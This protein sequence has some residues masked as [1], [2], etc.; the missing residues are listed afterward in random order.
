[1][2]PT[3]SLTTARELMLS[4]QLRAWGVK[5]PRALEAISKMPKE[6][7]VEEERKS[8]AYSDTELPIGQGEFSL[9]P[10]VVGRILES[11]A[12]QERDDILEIG[13]G[14]GYLTALCAELGF[15]VTSI[16]LC[17]EF[18]EKARTNLSSLRLSN[19]H[20]F[21]NDIFEYVKEKNKIFDVVIFTGSMP[22]MLPEFIELLGARGRL[23]AIVGKEPAMTACLWSKTGEQGAVVK[24][25]LFETVV[26]PLHN[27]PIE[28]RFSL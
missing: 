20:L 18:V 26:K 6:I 11:V 27:Y 25:S 1:M 8:L 9:P 14:S 15:H 10:K 3:A 7:F 23:F 5:N 28:E 24:K 21:Q 2:H 17:N 13:T 4:Q 16:D 19:F 12:I 22:S